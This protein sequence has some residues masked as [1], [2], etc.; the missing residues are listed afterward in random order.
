MRRMKIQSF[1]SNMKHKHEPS[2]QIS[3]A[4][5]T[6]WSRDTGPSQSQFDSD[7]F[8]PPP[9]YSPGS[10]DSR[11]PIPSPRR[12]LSPPQPTAP[13]INPPQQTIRSKRPVSAS[14]RTSHNRSQATAASDTSK[15]GNSLLPRR[16]STPQ[17]TI[18]S[19]AAAPAAGSSTAVAQTSRR[20]V[21]SPVRNRGNGNGNSIERINTAD[22]RRRPYS[23]LNA[24]VPGKR[25]I[26]V[27]MDREERRRGMG[28]NN[29]RGKE[30]VRET[31][32]N[33]DQT[34][35]QRGE[36]IKALREAAAA[37]VL[38]KKAQEQEELR[39]PLTPLLPC[40]VLL[41]SSTHTSLLI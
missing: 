12:L 18:S 6:A 16:S 39:S 35:D 9:Q 17:R 11:S 40:P 37:R 24:D 4:P 22:Q 1:L 3:T 13:C 33:M 28:G 21:T 34:V 5:S 26:S 41:S 38:A 8:T 25:E 30:I 14:G 15:N 7:A 27:H 29:Q 36:R 20:L 32:S 19:R 10:N 23:S 31:S 2:D